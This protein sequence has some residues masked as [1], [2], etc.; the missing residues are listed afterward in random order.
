MG[1]ALIRAP[2]AA[3]TRA[4]GLSTFAVRAFPIVRDVVVAA[5]VL[6]LPAALKL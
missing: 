1:R 4:H 5:V 2:A 3:E 6:A